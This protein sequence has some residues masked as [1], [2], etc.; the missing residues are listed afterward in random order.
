MA[1]DEL[2]ARMEQEAAEEP[3]ADPEPSEQVNH[4]SQSKLKSTGTKKVAGLKTKIGKL[5]QKLQTNNNLIEKLE[6]EAVARTLPKT[7]RERLDS[8]HQL[9]DKIN[10]ELEAKR[11]E[12][13]EAEEVVARKAEEFER[14]EM[15]AREKEE[16]TRAMTEA[17]A[18]FLVRLVIKY[19][20]KFAN[21]TDKNDAVWLHVHADFMKA[22]DACDLV[23]TD[24]RGVQALKT[25]CVL[26]TPPMPRPCPHVHETHLPRTP[27][28]P[29]V[30]EGARRVP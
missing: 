3:E 10:S 23:V 13:E 17:G 1:D 24:G 6:L 7:K 30:F 28:R 25:R 26:P 11:A 22:V 20:R 2:E 14:K 12:L 29:Q 8:L 15:E 19:D 21:R 16:H 9:V 18:E 4:T 5:E 27:L